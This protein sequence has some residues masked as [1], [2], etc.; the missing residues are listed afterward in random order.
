MV[1]TLVTAAALLCLTS[2][3][4]T[5][6]PSIDITTLVLE[7]DNVPGVG[8]VTRIDNVAVNTPG[9]WFVEAD[10]DFSNTE[11][12]QVLLKSDALFLRE[13]DALPLPEGA[14]LD[15]FDSINLNSDGNSGWNLFLDGTQGTFDDSGIYFNTT[16]VIQ[17]SDTSTAADFSPN[18]PYI[19]FFD[20]KMN[21][22]NQVMVVASVDDPAIPTTVD[23]AIVRLDLDSVG[24]L[25]SETVIAKEGDVLPGQTESITEFGTDPHESAFN[26]AGDILY[27][28]ELTGSTV[29]DEALYLNDALIAQ[30]GGPSPIDGRNYAFISGRGNDLNNNSSYV[31]K[32]RLDGDAASDVVLV[33]N[34]EVFKQEG[35]TFPAIAPFQLES[36][37]SNSGPVQIDDGGNVVW[38][39]DWNDP[40]TNID[41]GIF[42]NEHLMV[43]EGVTIID[44]SILDEIANVSDAFML[45]DDGKWL[46]FE[47]TLLG[48]INGAFMVNIDTSSGVGDGDL[49]L[50]SSTLSS[51]PNPFSQRISLRFRLSAAEDVS[52]EVFDVSGRLVKHLAQ[53]THAEGLHEAF[54]NGEDHGGVPVSAGIYFLRLK[55]GDR[56]E[57]SRIVRIR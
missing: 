29:E 56:L 18:T 49:G 24:S 16:L 45:S 36:F 35:E 23:R 25:L 50:A 38:Y 33:R 4:A 11:Q 30:K 21:D 9:D 5:A 27:I 8:N 42:W 34:D 40:N 17:E 39:G 13:D 6:Q 37:G 15:S 43:Q 54:W 22:G 55:A 57:T 1:K 53:G 32:A 14:R 10:T 48:G 31:F 19:G 41:T 2:L 12:D 51:H 26:E 3:S 28:V 7:G 47:G 44:G 46:I 20:A 52:L